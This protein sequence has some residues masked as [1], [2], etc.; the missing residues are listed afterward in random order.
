MGEMGGRTEGG[1]GRSCIS[2]VLAREHDPALCQSVSK[3]TPGPAPCTICISVSE[4][5]SGPKQTHS[6]LGTVRP[7][8]PGLNTLRRYSGAGFP[9]LA[10][11]WQLNRS[12]LK[13]LA[14][15]GKQPGRLEVDFALSLA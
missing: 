15:C 6:T 10:K 7:Q 1:G 9:T 5:S 4:R 14:A 12:Q 11:R 13:A 8:T 3:G 2:S